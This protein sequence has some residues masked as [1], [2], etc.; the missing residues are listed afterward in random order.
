METKTRF[1]WFLCFPG[2]SLERVWVLKSAHAECQNS[3]RQCAVPAA[4]VFNSALLRIRLCLLQLLFTILQH[5]SSPTIR[6]NIV[7]A[8]GDLAFRFPNEVEPWSPHF[9]AKLQDDDLTVRKHTLMVL[10]HLA[11]PNQ[12]KPNQTASRS[13]LASALNAIG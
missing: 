8:L 12:T 4:R 11:R 10:T 9:Y 7:I 1:S 13:P 2:F 3:R 5:D 6:A